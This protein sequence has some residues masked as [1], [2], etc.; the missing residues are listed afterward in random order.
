MSLNTVKAILIINAWTKET[1]MKAALARKSGKGK[2]SKDYAMHRDDIKRALDHAKKYGTKGT[3]PASK[4]LPSNRVARLEKLYTA[5]MLKAALKSREEKAGGSS[6]QSN[7]Q[8]GSMTGL[9]S[10]KYGGSGYPKK[11]KK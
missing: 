1:R 2:S 5:S 9:A 7:I 3:D 4:K 8:G 6:T 10:K 11:G